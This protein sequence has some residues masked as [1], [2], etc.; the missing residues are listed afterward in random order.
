MLPRCPANLPVT[1]PES[2]TSEHVKP[3]LKH[4]QPHE[5]HINSDKSGH[6]STPSNLHGV[7]ARQALLLS[8][9]T[10]HSPRD[11]CNVA[12]TLTLPAPLIG[13][14]SPKDASVKSDDV[15]VPPRRVK[16][17]VLIKTSTKTSGLPSLPQPT[18]QKKLPLPIF[19]SSTSGF[20]SSGKISPLPVPVSLKMSPSDGYLASC[21]PSPLRI[22]LIPTTASKKLSSKMKK[23]LNKKKRGGKKKKLVCNE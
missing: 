2:F 18:C 4:I 7:N 15:Y 11:V 12:S 3:V 20:K 14:S 1:P 13:H 17:L 9:N 19:T 16:P 8:V 6:I 10:S 22:T 5:K 23:M 21:S